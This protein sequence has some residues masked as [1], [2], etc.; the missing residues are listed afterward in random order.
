MNITES[1]QI[2]KNAGLSP[3][4]LE[5]L[6]RLLPALPFVAGLTQAETGL[7]LLT[8][9][10]RLL[11]IATSMP[12]TACLEAL[13]PPAGTMVQPSE[14]PLVE[15]VLIRGNFLHGWRERDYG[16][17]LPFWAFA[18]EDRQGRIFAVTLLGGD[19]AEEFPYMSIVQAAQLA[20][21]EAKKM[22]KTH[23][24]RPLALGD[25]ILFA[26]G[27]GRIAYANNAARHLYQ[28]LG[29]G[30]LKGMT[31]FDQRLYRRV[32]KETVRRDQPEEKEIEAAGR[33]LLHRE[34]PLTDGGEAK[35]R[36]VILR[37]ITEA[38]QKERETRAQ[39]AI[40]QEVHHR[41]K[42][43]LQTVASLLRMQA[44]R[45]KDAAA[46]KALQEATARVLAIAQTHAFLSLAPQ[47]GLH[48]RALF[49]EVEQTLRSYAVPQ[50]FDLQTTY[51]GD[52]ITLPAQCSLNFALVLHELFLNA[53]EHGFRGRQKGTICLSVQREGTT[54]RLTFTDDGQGFPEDFR[55]HK[56][57]GLSICQA[58][59]EEEMGGKISFCNGEE[60]GAMVEMKLT[61]IE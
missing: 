13:L 19:T 14:E 41:V 26:D 45:Q 39:A 12:T 60:G 22:S 53:L 59:V 7:W 9:A 32:T 27:H 23:D 43:N 57:L 4:H 15:R 35:G 2:A 34:I 16:E 3:F 11:L 55:T 17:R 8:P 37:D 21:M 20:M 54:A 38:L 24:F 36:I 46:Q 42:N 29:I 33:T 25:G 48:V 47:A 40:L 28:M 5:T 1:L 6:R 61:A 18:L 58:I 56:S 52:A 31:L 10:H 50:G 49:A 51:E 30:N 44:R